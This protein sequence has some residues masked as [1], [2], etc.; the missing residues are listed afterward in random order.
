M[1]KT[2]VNATGDVLQIR[3]ELAMIQSALAAA[4]ASELESEISDRGRGASIYH[5]FA[6]QGS[7]PV[8]DFASWVCV[9][10]KCSRVREGGG[11]LKLD[12]WAIVH[13]ERMHHRLDEDV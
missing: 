9:E 5:A 7:I 11:E 12:D 2:L 8:R 1:T 4:Q 10:M 6:N 13:N 3:K